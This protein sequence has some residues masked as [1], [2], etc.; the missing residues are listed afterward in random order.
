MYFQTN[1]ASLIDPGNGL[2]LEHLKREE[3]LSAESIDYTT[4]QVARQDFPQGAAKG[5]I[6]FAPSTNINSSNDKLKTQN[7]ML[8]L[9]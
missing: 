2:L 8:E 7:Y 5:N 4:M 6:D 1:N 9:T 3:D